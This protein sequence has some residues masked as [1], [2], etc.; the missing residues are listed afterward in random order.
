MP[1]P[2]YRHAKRQKELQRKNKQERKQ[3]RRS[4]RTGDD[5]STT[6]GDGTPPGAA[7]PSSGKPE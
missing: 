1:S 6:A 7:Q 3:Q 4:G 5:A 2:N